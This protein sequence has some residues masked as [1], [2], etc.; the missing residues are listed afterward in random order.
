MSH[1]R[2]RSSHLKSTGTTEVFKKAFNH[3]RN[4]GNYF[5][6]IGVEEAKV[7]SFAGQIDIEVVRKVRDE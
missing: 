7:T 4:F 2:Q 3:V 5:T 6:C 1:A